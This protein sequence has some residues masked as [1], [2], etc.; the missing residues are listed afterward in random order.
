MI[1][2]DPFAS[3]HPMYRVGAQ[4]S[5]AVRAHENISRRAARERAVELLDIVG[6]PRAREASR[7]YPHQFSGG[8][9]QRALI[10]MALAHTPDV[11][12][13]DEPTTALDVTIQ[14]QILELIEDVKQ[15]I[16]MD[17]ILV[18]HDLGIIAQ[19][20]DRVLVMYAGRTVQ[21]GTTVTSS[22]GPGTPT[23]GDSW[24]RCPAPT[25]L[26]ARWFPSMVCRRR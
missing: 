4:V 13:A 8:M 22:I 2:Q 19:V 11:L 20:A 23:P 18:T 7:D 15:E 25:P 24:T 1:F 26:A 5:E 21:T 17:V 9:R 14:A 16:Q 10:A 12:I 3:L 6:I